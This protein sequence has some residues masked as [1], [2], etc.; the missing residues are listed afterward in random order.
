MTNVFQSTHPLIQHKLTLLRDVKTEPKRFREL[1]REVT[2]L[3]LYEATEDLIPVERPV[4]TPMGSAMGKV[5]VEEIAFA[6]ILR[7]GLTMVDPAM[8]MIPTAQIWHIGLYREEETLQP[9]EYYTNVPKK[10]TAE[11]AFILDPMLATGGSA[12]A[13]VDIL[14]RSG[15]RSIKFVGLI[16]APEGIERFCGAHPHVPIYLAAVDER[17]N[18]IGYIVPGLG[19]AGDRLFGTS[20]HRLS[21]D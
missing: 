1:V 19:D 6:P 11:I 18:E 17:L 2:W 10:P 20:R 15:V 9:I 8:E 3:L 4:T 14:K 13:A 7:A 21:G 5:L 12:V 16:A